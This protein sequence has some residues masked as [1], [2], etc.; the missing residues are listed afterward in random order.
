M[1]AR[2]AGPKGLHYMLAA[3]LVCGTATSF[4]QSQAE[5]AP[6]DADSWVRTSQTFAVNNQP[7][8]ALDA[9][10]RAFELSPDSVDV[11]RARATL[12]TW[13]GEYGTARDSY[14]RLLKRLPGDHEAVLNLAR[15]AAWA[16][17]T[18]A[19]V[20]AYARY[21][22]LEPNAA[23]AWIELARTEGWRGNYSAALRNLDQYEARFGGDQRHA[24]EKAAVLARAGRPDE[25]IGILDPLLLE[26]PDDYDLN[27]TRTVA[28]TTLQRRREAAASLQTV[29][30]L[31]PGTP[32]TQSAERLYRTALAPVVDPVMNV[33]SDSSTLTVRRLAPRAAMTFA[34]GTT[35]A[36]GSEHDWLSARRG[37]GLEQVNGTETA[38]HDHVWIGAAHQFGRIAVGGQIGQARTVR[39][40]TVYEIT[41]DLRPV[42]GVTLVLQ[43]DAGFFVVS[44]R[45]IGL[46]LRQVGHRA[47]LEW[48]PAIRWQIVSDIR[49]QTLSDGNHRWEFTVSPRYGLARTEQVNLDLG[50]TV[51][52]LR[53]TTNYDHGYYDPA[54]SDFYAVTAFPYWKVRE[55]VGIG[56]SVAMGVQRDDFSPRFRPGGHAAAEATFGIYHAWALKLTAAGTLNQRLG[57]GAFRGRTVGVTLIKRF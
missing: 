9:I 18:D 14:E 5:P 31:Q 32:Q 30:R 52:Q 54:R 19:A 49:E 33:Y 28:L 36:A 2:T 22:H 25:A 17:K 41:V 23:G 57:S 24:R 48:S 26:H 7:A 37:S 51:S 43:R 21:L 1:R 13:N 15:V 47:S 50:L 53:T 42:D 12:A 35:L 34:G 10:E 44:P 3:F 6:Q 46:G 56:A 20:D 55:S 11:L 38:R 45:T 4:A 29:R 27:L 16:G 8:Q 40:L 39:D